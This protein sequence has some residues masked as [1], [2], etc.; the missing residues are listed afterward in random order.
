M[1]S[2]K[3]GNREGR[4]KRDKEEK[5]EENENLYCSLDDIHF[6]THSLVHNTSLYCKNTK[7]FLRWIQPHAMKTWGT[8]SVTPCTLNL[9]ELSPHLSQS[10]LLIKA[11]GAHYTEQSAGHKL[12]LD[13]AKK[14]KCFAVARNRTARLEGFKTQNELS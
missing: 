3:N 10:N 5:R 7:L 12:G 11:H 2:R 1:V 6:L 4:G 13:T 14:R 9:T 8:G